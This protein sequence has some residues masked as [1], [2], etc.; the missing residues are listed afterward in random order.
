MLIKINDTLAVNS[1]YVVSVDLNTATEF[2]KSV[3]GM[4]IYILNR[5]QPIELKFMQDAERMFLYDRISRA[6]NN[7]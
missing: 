4:S 7:G 2:G 5:A 1:R 3:Y 6:L